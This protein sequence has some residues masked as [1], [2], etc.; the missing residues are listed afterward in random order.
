MELAKDIANDKLSD[1]IFPILKRAFPNTPIVARN[2]QPLRVNFRGVSDFGMK[3]Q[4]DAFVRLILSDQRLSHTVTQIVL[5]SLGE[6]FSRDIEV[7]STPFIA[8]LLR[9]L[10]TEESRLADS[11]TQNNG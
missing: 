7:N 5:Q 10:I 6:A 9:D 2:W 3:L 11:T 8:A 1:E 4:M